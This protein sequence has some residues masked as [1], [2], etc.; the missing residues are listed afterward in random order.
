MDFDVT[1]GALSIEQ[2][3]S[4]K[5]NK[6]TVQTPAGDHCVSADIVN[7]NSEDC[8]RSPRTIEEIHKRINS[9]M[10]CTSTGYV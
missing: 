10:Y 8:T 9:E 1:S 2:N 5:Q 6:V 4:I 3:P 7:M